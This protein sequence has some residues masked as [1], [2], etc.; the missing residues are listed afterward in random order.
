[1]FPGPAWGRYKFEKGEIVLIFAYPGDFNAIIREA[2]AQYSSIEMR[3]KERGNRDDL[4]LTMF[5]P[6]LYTKRG[7]LLH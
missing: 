2:R 1:M 7:V 5:Q 4:R 3:A 6:W